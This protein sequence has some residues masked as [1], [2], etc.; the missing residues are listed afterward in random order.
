MDKIIKKVQQDYIAAK[1]RGDIG[2][3]SPHWSRDGDDYL[4]TT[5]GIALY[6]IPSEKLHVKLLET[7]QS[8]VLERVAK[9]ETGY[10]PAEY[11]GVRDGGLAVFKAGGLVVVADAKKAKI[12]TD[13][14]GGTCKIQ[15][16]KTAI[17]FYD[18]EGQFVG[19]LLPVRQKLGQDYDL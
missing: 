8:S 3:R 15:S 18:A 12:F 4:L 7:D 19:L 17:K 16:E 9:N 11:R 5:D 10:L 14:K 2:P 1:L 6:R 13:I